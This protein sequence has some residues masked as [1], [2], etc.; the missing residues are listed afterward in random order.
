MQITGELMN[1][2]PTM[3][4]DDAILAIDSLEHPATDALIYGRA[5][6]RHAVLVDA[7]DRPLARILTK[8]TDEGLI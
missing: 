6:V 5:T 4:L 2:L 1:S 7:D 8:L 3:T